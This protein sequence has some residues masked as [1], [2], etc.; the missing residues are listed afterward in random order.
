MLIPFGMVLAFFTFIAIH[1]HF[2]LDDI[3]KGESKKSS[4]KPRT[5][6]A[7]KTLKLFQK[8]QFSQLEQI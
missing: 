2:A 8:W 7:V 1:S 3:H 4:K 6:T 5:K